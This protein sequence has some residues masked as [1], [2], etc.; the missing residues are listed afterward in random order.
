MGI[1]KEWAKITMD[2]KSDFSGH[3][4]N[5]FHCRSTGV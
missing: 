5:D 4:P 3:E 2:M 1:A